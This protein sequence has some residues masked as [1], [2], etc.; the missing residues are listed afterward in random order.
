ML[1]KTVQSNHVFF[2]EC[3]STEASI[4]VIRVADATSHVAF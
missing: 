1:L 3:F 2:S 4:A